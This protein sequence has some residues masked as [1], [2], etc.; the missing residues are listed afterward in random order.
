[1]DQWRRRGVALASGLS[2]SVR[3]SRLAAASAAVKNHRQPHRLVLDLS[4]LRGELVEPV[5]RGEVARRAPAVVPAHV[6]RFAAARLREEISDDVPVAVY[7][8]L[9]YRAVPVH[10]HDVSADAGRFGIGFALGLLRLRANQ[11]PAAAAAAAARVVLNARPQ[12]RV[13]SPP[14]RRPHVHAGQRREPRRDV[15]VPAPHREVE[16]AVAVVGFRGRV[17]AA[18]RVVPYKAMS[19]WSS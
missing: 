4:Q 14:V 10:V 12:N 19:G 2:A 11:T 17:G 3:R 16:R 6:L 18:L 5:L 7:R 9:V 15:H 1:M 8:A 13:A